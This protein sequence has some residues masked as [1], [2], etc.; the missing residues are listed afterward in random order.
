MFGLASEYYKLADAGTRPPRPTPG[1][2]RREALS[3]DLIARLGTN[4]SAVAEARRAAEYGADAL[5]P[6]PPFFL[7]TPL[8]DIVT[9]LRRRF[10]RLPPNSDPVCTASYWA[11]DDPRPLPRSAAICRIL[12]VS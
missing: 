4:L 6:T 10:G 1:E 2:A 8:N 11:S 3:G 7:G 5:T 9:H 12:S